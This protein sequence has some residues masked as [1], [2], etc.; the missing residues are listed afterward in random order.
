M[1]HLLSINELF[2]KSI[3]DINIIEASVNKDSENAIGKIDVLIKDIPY[4][5]NFQIK[6]FHSGT[7]VFISFYVINSQKFVSDKSKYG[8]YDYKFIVNNS[9][10]IDVLNSLPMALEKYKSLLSPQYDNLE[11]NG[12]YYDADEEKR[13]NIYE[14]FF[15]IKLGD[16]LQSIGTGDSYFIMAKLKEPVQLKNL[17]L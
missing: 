3:S 17:Y 16:K 8:S 10:M 9:M 13:K 6:R 15:K 4:R 11:V 2:D 14:Y 7:Y 5:F 12:F 1:K